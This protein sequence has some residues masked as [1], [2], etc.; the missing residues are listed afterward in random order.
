VKYVQVCW[1]DDPPCGVC[2][3]GKEV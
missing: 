1:L 2:R 3:D